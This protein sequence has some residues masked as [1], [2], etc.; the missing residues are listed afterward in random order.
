ME[1]REYKVINESNFS[2]TIP[3]TAVQG[4]SAGVQKFS[5]SSTCLYILNCFLIHLEE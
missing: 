5:N 3:Q 1:K 2:L 4:Q